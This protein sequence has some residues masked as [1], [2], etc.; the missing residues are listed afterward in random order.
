MAKIHLN[1]IAHSY[2]P[3][4]NG[5]DDYALKSMEH[6]W[7]DGKTYAL[8]GPS[9][10]GKTT[11]L[12]IISGLLTPSEGHVLFGDDDVTSLPTEERNIAQVFQFPVIYDTMSVRQNLAFPLKNRG[13]SVEAINARV[14]EIASMLGLT[15][16]LD[17]RALNLSSDAKQIISLGRGLVRDDVNA[18]L[19]DEPLTMIDPHKKWL[20]RSKLKKLHQEFGF[21]MV[22]VTHDQTE[23]MTFADHVVVMKDGEILQVGTPKE[24]FERPRHTFV[25]HFIGSPGMNF[26]P[27]SL[28]GNKAKFNGQTIKLNHDYSTD[29]SDNIML[30]IRPEYIAVTTPDNGGIIASVTN[31][32][33]LGKHKIVRMTIGDHTLSAIV[34]EETEIS[35]NEVSISF[36]PEN[37]LIYRNNLLIEKDK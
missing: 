10:C 19:F 11:L 23:A 34:P 12:N 29:I 2:Q 20:L 18:I 26:L 24:L 7:E 22:Y 14:E 15:D 3:N 36:T 28:E 5:P 31:V 32:E 33:D 17:S 8:L 27:V 4:P 6:I 30:G 16:Q 13:E 9:G 37:T 35:T 1:N 21:T 25:G